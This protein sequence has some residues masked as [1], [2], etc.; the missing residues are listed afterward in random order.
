MKPMQFEAGDYMIKPGD[1]Q[2]CILIIGQGKAE[3]S[4]TINDNYLNEIH[5]YIY[6][7]NV[8]TR[9]KGFSEMWNM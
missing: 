7:N 3:V 1:I 9:N 8:R 2:D 4:C 5:N 6:H